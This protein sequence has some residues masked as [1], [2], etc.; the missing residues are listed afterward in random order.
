MSRPKGSKNKSKINNTVSNIPVKEKQSD[1]SASQFTNNIMFSAEQFANLFVTQYSKFIENY[2]TNG[3]YNPIYANNLMKRFNTTSDKPTIND[4]VRWLGNPRY[5]E[6]QLRGMSDWLTYASQ[7]YNRTI[8]YV[9]NILNFDYELIPINPPHIDASSKEIDLY[10]KQKVINNEWLRKF[11]VK[12]QCTNVVLDV[13]KSGGKYYYLRHSMNS[14]YLQG[15]PDDYCYINGRVDSVGYT[16]AMNMAFFYQCP[17][18]IAGFA[19][20]FAQWYQEF[21]D[22]KATLNEKANPYRQMPVDRAV[23]FKMDD[24]RPEMIPPFAGSFKNALEVEDYQDLVKLKSQLQTFQLLYLEIPKDSDGKPTISAQDAITYT[25]VAQSQVPTGTGLVSTPMHMDQVKFDNSQNLN[26]I[27]GLGANNYYQDAGISPTLFGSDT[28]SAVGITNSIQTDFLEFSPLYNQFERF[29]NLQL[30]KIDGKYDFAIKF[31]RRSSYDLEND[32]KNSMTYVD[33]G[34]PITMALSARGYEPWQY[35]NVIID[36]KISNY[37]NKLVVPQTAY[38]NSGKNGGGRPSA[39]D[40]GQTISDSN[41]ATRSQGSNADKQFSKHVCLN[42][43][44]EISEK[45][46][47]KDFCDIECMKQYLENNKD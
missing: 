47:Y 5:F 31:L 34:L 24:T 33:H 27:I 11:R 41:D 35:E 10:Q 26:N 17:E 23:V 42:C 7:Y 13:A 20:E 18:S 32:Q 3:W 45:G 46:E 15:M 14:D 37:N 25:A 21:L 19:P 1:V 4:I 43:G 2:A 28:K 40:K 12:E 38:T 22:K 39:E 29:I 44:T 6:Q 8:N 36:G 16:Y 30:S 9:A